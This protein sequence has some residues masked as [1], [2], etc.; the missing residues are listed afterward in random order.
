MNYPAK[1]ALCGHT[2]DSEDDAMWWHGYGNCV[3]ITDEMWEQWEREA[4]E[5]ERHGN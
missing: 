4:K 3:D 5:S 1:C 2:I